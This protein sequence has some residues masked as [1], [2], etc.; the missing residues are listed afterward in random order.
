MLLKIVFTNSRFNT[1]HILL[2]IEIL[3]TNRV[4]NTCYALVEK[5]CRLDTSKR[6]H[7]I[8]IIVPEPSLQ[9][10]VLQKITIL[11]YHVNILWFQICNEKCPNQIVFSLNI[12]LIS[13]LIFTVTCTQL[14][15]KPRLLV[16]WKY[17]NSIHNSLRYYRVEYYNLYR[18]EL[19]ILW[20]T[21]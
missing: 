13:F 4:H 21:K 6:K 17:F 9:D 2:K 15:L 8:L 10:I 18:Y 1:T 5:T 16:Y 20:T 14:L 7:F 11:S 12:I 19:T 3:Y